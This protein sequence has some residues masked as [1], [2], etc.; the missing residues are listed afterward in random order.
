MV[1]LEMKLEMNNGH[2][3]CYIRTDNKFIEAHH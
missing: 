3:Y 2:W 1:I